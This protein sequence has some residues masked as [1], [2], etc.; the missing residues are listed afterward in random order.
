MKKL[1]SL[2]LTLA[3][4]ASL[5]IIPAAAAVPFTDIGTLDEYAQ[6]NIEYLYNEGVMTGTSETTFSPDA[7]YTRAMFVTMLGR[8]SGV[9][10]SEYT[11]SVFS[12]VPA[13]RWDSPYIA[14]AAEIG[15]VN[16]VGNGRFDPTGIITLEQYATI[17]D[18]FLGMLDVSIVYD[19]TGD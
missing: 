7:Y 2:L 11:G 16:G 12:D 19:A 8:M 1:F 9:D 15:L 13:G 6:D 5:L 3:L 4:T 10:P 18:R 17:V 14:W